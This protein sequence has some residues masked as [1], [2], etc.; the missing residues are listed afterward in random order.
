MHVQNRLPCRRSTIHTDIVAIRLVTILKP[1]L[2]F[3]DQLHDGFLFSSSKV[4][5]VGSV[6]IGDDQ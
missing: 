3:L 1:M 6:P 5:P 4:K 2:T